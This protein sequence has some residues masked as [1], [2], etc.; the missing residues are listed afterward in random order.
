MTDTSTTVEAA[1]TKAIPTADLAGHVVLWQFPSNEISYSEVREALIF[2]DLDPDLAKELRPAAA[3]SRAAKG[4]KEERRIDKVRQVK[5]VIKFQLTGVVKGEHIDFHRQTDIELDSETGVIHCPDDEIQ[6]KAR[7]L[8]KA[9]IVTRT[10]NDCTKMV[11]LLFRD[12]ADLF[13][14]IPEKGVAYFVPIEHAKFL[15]KVQ[16][17]ATA[18]GGSLYPFPVPKG[19]AVGDRSVKQT[20]AS[21]LQAM[22]DELNQTVSDWDHTTRSSTE[23]KAVKRWE[24][25]TY[26]TEAYAAYLESEKENLDKALVEAKSKLTAKILEVE[27]EKEIMKDDAVEAGDAAGH[28]AADDLVASLSA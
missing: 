11:Q 19:T 21:G 22:V 2:A 26:R 15:E 13:P 18:C 28:A 8:F 25:I 9:A 7:D 10:S 24:A 12:N 5:G 27:M 4:L 23:S 20:I 14:V 6:Q 16:Q 17:F 3:F 1:T